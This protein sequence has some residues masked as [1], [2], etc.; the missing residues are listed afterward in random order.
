VPQVPALV[1]VVD[2]AGGEMHLTP[3][4]GLLDLAAPPPP[5]EVLLRTMDRCVVGLMC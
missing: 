3:P 4:E 1:P 5:E 2:V